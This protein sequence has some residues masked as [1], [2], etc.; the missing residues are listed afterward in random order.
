MGD[1]GAPPETVLHRRILFEWIHKTID[2]GRAY[3]SSQAYKP[4]RGDPPSANIAAECDQAVVLGPYTLDNVS[5]GAITSE[6][7]ARQ[8]HDVVRD[9]APGEHPSHVH[10]VSRPGFAKSALHRQQKNLANETLWIAGAQ[11]WEPLD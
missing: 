1:A 11:T 9:V 8:D 10:I 7:C 5:V 4:R 3:L 2:E 6:A